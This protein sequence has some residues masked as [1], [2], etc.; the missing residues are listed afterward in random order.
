MLG[1]SCGRIC[2]S[3]RYARCREL[4]REMGDRKSE[5]WACVQLAQT[6][7]SAASDEEKQELELRAKAKEEKAHCCTQGCWIRTELVPV[8]ICCLQRPEM[9]ESLQILPDSQTSSVP[10]Y[11]ACLRNLFAVVRHLSAL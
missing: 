4:Q 11:A 1:R 7:L 3:E 9:K 5:A 2:K 10:L 6:L 8:C